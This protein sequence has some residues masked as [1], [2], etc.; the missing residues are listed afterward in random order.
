LISRWLRAHLL[1]GSTRLAHPVIPFINETL[2]EKVAR[3]EGEIAKVSGKL[4]DK[5]FIKRARKKP[6]SH[7][8]ESAWQISPA[9]W[10]S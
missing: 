5:G 2:W 9:R 6:S 8:K 4:A 3:L 10:T 1:A 7:C